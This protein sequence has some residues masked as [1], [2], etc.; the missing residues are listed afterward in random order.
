MWADS[1]GN[2]LQDGGETGVA[3]VTVTLSDCTTGASLA[4]AQTDGNGEYRFS[5]LA[6]GRYQLV[7]TAP[8]GTQF[9]PRRVGSNRRIDSDATAAGR[10]GC[11]RAVAGR[12][13][14]QFDAG[15]SGEIPPGGGGGS[16]P[17][18]GVV[19]GGTASAGDRV[20]D[21]L[22]GNG[23]QDAGEPGVAGVLVTLQNCSGTALSSMQTSADGRYRFTEM[24]AGS[25]Q[26][27]FTAP[28]GRGFTSRGQ[29]SN[30]KQDSN[31]KADGTTGCF[32]LRN[33]NVRNT[34]DAGL[35]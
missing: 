25:Y 30:H 26:L 6:E 29:G 11:P 32:S 35:R 27:L 9:S 1:N 7:V 24:P 5:D 13:K 34:W 15:L 17:G 18:N 28:A 23:I 21:D 19:G 33:G 12:F 22:N 8:P 16:E 31:A 3:G 20:W 4:T 10:L 14:D 2:G